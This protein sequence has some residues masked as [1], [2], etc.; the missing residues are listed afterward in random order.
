MVVEEIRR[1]AASLGLKHAECMDKGEL[2]R[3]IQAMEGK[4]PCFDQQTCRPSLH[5]RCHWKRDCRA[6]LEPAHGLI[7]TDN[8]VV[9]H[10]IVTLLASS[11]GWKMKIVHKDRQAYALMQQGNTDVVVADIDAADLGGLAVLSYAKHHWP[12]IMA[13]AIA[14]NDDP[15]LKKLAQDLGG[16]LGFFR[17]VKGTIE[18]DIH[19][20]ADTHPAYRPSIGDSAD[21]SRIPSAG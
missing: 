4:R 6:R 18:L 12:S 20:D 10:Q 16:C 17:R 13:Y 15:F 3:A 21:L 5:H 9:G 11:Y 7:L 14:R 1:L 2:I 8:I 19:S